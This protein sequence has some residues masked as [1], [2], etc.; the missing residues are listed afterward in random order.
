MIPMTTEIGGR[1]YERDTDRLFIQLFRGR[2]DAVEALARAALGCS[3]NCMPL[4][5]V[6]KA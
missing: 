1:V 6:D 2:P 5:L 4:G 3:A